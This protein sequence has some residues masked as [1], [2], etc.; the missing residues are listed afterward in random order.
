MIKELCDFCG[1]EMC[2]KDRRAT[3]TIQRP[4]RSSEPEA[5]FV[6]FFGLASGDAGEQKVMCGECLGHLLAVSERVARE[7]ATRRQ[8]DYFVTAIEKEMADS[9]AKAIAKEM[10]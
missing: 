6:R 9:I 5:S 10:K 1:D 2:D 7:K 8:P 3:F 4:R